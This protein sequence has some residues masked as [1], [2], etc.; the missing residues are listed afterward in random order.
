[1]AK[2]PSEYLTKTKAKEADEKADKKGDDKG[3]D[4]KKAPRKNAL[5]DFIAKHKN[6]K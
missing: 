5:I 6:V 1:M 3:K 4:D 2:A